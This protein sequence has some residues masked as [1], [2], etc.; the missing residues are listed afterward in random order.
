M[1]LEPVDLKNIADALVNLKYDLIAINLIVLCIAILSVYFLARIKKSA[2]LKEINNNFN[3]VLE[4]QAELAEETG[5]IKQSLDKDSI[6]YQIKLNAYHD[7]SIESINDI[8]VAIIKLREAAKNLGFTRTDE[9]NKN[10]FTVVSEFRYI[11]DTKKIWIPKSLSDHIECVAIELDNRSHTFITSTTREK[12]IDRLSENQVNKIFDDQEAFY[13]YM[14]Q[15]I[16][17][18]FDEL[19]EKISES[20]GT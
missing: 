14:N 8:Y 17:I 4:Q 9:E 5:K 12:H 10:F 13:D 6:N 7:K 20:V 19:V 11:F 2:E 3:T 18:I 16:G 15:E 1:S